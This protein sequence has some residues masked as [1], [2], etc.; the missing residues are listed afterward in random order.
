ME[1]TCS[2]EG[3]WFYLLM[4]ELLGKEP[5]FENCPFY[6]K[7]VFTPDPIDGKVQTAKVV[8]DCINRRLLLFNMTQ[9]FPR[10]VGVQK[11]QEEMRNKSS[12]ATVLF[13]K[14]V[15]TIMDKKHEVSFK[16]KNN[17]NMQIL[18]DSGVGRS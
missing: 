7:T 16:E 1:D 11:S 2:K 15:Q 9:V 6:M 4:K 5:K 18:S 12:E 10:M 3:C 14:M 8:E 17:A 13:G